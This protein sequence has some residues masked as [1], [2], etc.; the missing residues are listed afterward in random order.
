MRA[1]STSSG[2]GFAHFGAFAGFGK[3]QRVRIACKCF[4]KCR[5]RLIIKVAVLAAAAGLLRLAGESLDGAMLLSG[6]DKESLTATCKLKDHALCARSSTAV[7]AVSVT[8]LSGFLRY[9]KTQYAIGLNNT[10]GK[11]RCDAAAGSPSEA[12]SGLAFAFLPRLWTY[13][14]L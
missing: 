1:L 2:L 14:V 13:R 12:A 7:K 5:L 9:V 4:K 6:Y 8:D 11:P 3:G 10:N